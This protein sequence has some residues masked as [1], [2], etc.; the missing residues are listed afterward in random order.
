MKHS[1]QEFHIKY[2]LVPVGKTADNVV[3]VLHN[4]NT[5]KQEV[6]GTKAYEE[7][8]WLSQDQGCFY[9]LGHVMQT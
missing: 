8:S 2:V 1:I 4:I 9:Y 6:R 7:T 5:S 3:A